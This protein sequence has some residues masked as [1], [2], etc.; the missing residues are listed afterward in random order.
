[1]YRLRP[2][3]DSIGQPSSDGVFTSGLL[4]SISSTFCAVL[5]SEKS[6]PA[7]AERGVSGSAAIG[8]AGCEG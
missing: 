2:S 6:G 5:Q 3:G 4:P 7:N 8:G 1:M